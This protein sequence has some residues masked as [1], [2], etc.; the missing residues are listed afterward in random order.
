MATTLEGLAYAVARGAVRAY[1]D[2]MEE[3]AHALEE[4]PNEADRLRAQRFRDAVMRQRQI[5][6][7][8]DNPAPGGESD[9]GANLDKVT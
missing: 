1:L 5:N 2:V 7:R 4:S 8:P 9:H 6:T 3:R